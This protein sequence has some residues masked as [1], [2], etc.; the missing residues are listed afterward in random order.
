MIEFEKVT[1]YYKDTKAL[2]DISFRIDNEKTT[3]IIGHNGAGK[4][5]MFMVANGLTKIKQGEV[6]INDYTLS[7]NRKKLQESTG[8]FTDRLHL[9][10]ILTVKECIMYFLRVNKRSSTSYAE[11]ADSF[12]FAGYEKKQIADLSTGMLKRVLLAVSMIN[13][14]RVLFLD[15]PFTG[16]DPE[17]RREFAKVV[18]RAQQQ[19]GTQIL[20]A[21]HDLWELETL[22]D[23]LLLLQNGRLIVNSSLQELMKTYFPATVMAI[24]LFT[25]NRNDLLYLQQEAKKASGT[26]IDPIPGTDEEIYKFHI[27]SGFFQQ[28]LKL[29]PEGIRILSIR[30]LQPSLDELYFKITNLQ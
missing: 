27:D 16:L 25:G 30:D 20:I 7:R 1:K 4:T 14:P 26:R 24:E 28:F 2:D 29:V 19:Y 8:L 17:S 10:N 3:G 6:R 11:L 23:N 13:Q 22:I 21:S 12:C 9:Y 18:K 5:T 15:E